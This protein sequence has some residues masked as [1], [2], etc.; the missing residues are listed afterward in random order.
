MAVNTVQFNQF[1][2]LMLAQMVKKL[3][4]IYRNRRCNAAATKHANGP[5]PK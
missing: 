5:Y 1:A 4:A 3:P 2:K